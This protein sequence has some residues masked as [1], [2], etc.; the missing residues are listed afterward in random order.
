MFASLIEICAN[1]H[2]P[3][4]TQSPPQ[5]Q[6][7]QQQ[8][9]QPQPSQPRIKNGPI[10]ISNPLPFGGFNS[11]SSKANPFSHPSTFTMPKQ[12]TP[13]PSLTYPAAFHPVSEQQ[14]QQ[15][16]P[17]QQRQ[18]YGNTNTNTNTNVNN[19]SFT[20]QQPLQSTQQPFSITTP[21]I[22]FDCDDAIQHIRNCKSCKKKL[23]QIQDNDSSSVGIEDI[24]EII[25]F[26]SAGVF[27]LYVVD[28]F[29][30]MRK[31]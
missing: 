13:A 30:N 4:F 26:V 10:N 11:D 24:F 14:F 3:Y 17:F 1:D 12:I 20:E 22:D 19:P 18:P 29:V 21:G 6:L 31:K 27:F 7:S 8:Q 5:Q 23:S 9:Q 25:T 16:Q 2:R 28:S 15:Y